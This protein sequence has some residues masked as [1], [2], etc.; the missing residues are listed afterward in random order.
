M[1][2]HMP[3]YNIPLCSVSALVWC[4]CMTVLTVL[5]V[6]ARL[7]CGLAY[8]Q[9]HHNKAVRFLKHELER[10]HIAVSTLNVNVIMYLYL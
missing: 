9:H 5:G 6:S 4:W 1:L 7:K 3:V 2:A 10:L 8:T